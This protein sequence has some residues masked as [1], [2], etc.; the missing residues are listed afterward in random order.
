MSDTTATTE[1]AAEEQR[2]A[3]RREATRVAERRYRHAL[4]SGT[5]HMA[6]M[7]E[8]WSA[9]TLARRKLARVQA[10]IGKAKARQ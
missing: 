7:L 3:A 8:P 2:D 4:L 5:S 10:A 1:L 6:L 9:E